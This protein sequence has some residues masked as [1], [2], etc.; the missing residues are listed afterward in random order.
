M[1]RQTAQNASS[2]YLIAISSRLEIFPYDLGDRFI[3][4]GAWVIRNSRA[5]ERCEAVTIWKL[6]RQNQS[7]LPLFIILTGDRISSSVAQSPPPTQ[8]PGLWPRRPVGRLAQINPSCAVAT[9]ARNSHFSWGSWNGPHTVG[10]LYI[11]NQDRWNPY[12]VGSCIL[13]SDALLFL[14]QLLFLSRYPIW[15]TLL[16]N[17]K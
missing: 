16:S 4:A 14:K 12:A 2:R 10:S 15:F 1:W 7:K 11:Q 9:F 17:T 5:L 8:R 3:D 6:L 13:K